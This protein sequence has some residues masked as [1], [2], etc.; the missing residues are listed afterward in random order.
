MIDLDTAPE[1]TTR[2]ELQY[3]V[4]V[5]L[6]LIDAVKVCCVQGMANMIVNVHLE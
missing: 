1:L 5:V 4:N 3:Q 6:I 2:A